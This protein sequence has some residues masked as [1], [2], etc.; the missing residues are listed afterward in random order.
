MIAKKEFL[1]LAVLLV[2]LSGCCQ[3]CRKKSTSEPVKKAKKT[4]AYN[5]AAMPQAG[6]ELALND[7]FVD[8]SDLDDFITQTN[9]D[10]TRLAADEGESTVE[11][12]E[13]LA[14]MDEYA[15]DEE[16]DLNWES[17]A[18]TPERNLRTV[19]FGFNKY[20]VAN[21]QNDVIEQNALQISNALCEADSRGEEL[22]VVVEA[23]A[24]HSAGA[25][26]YNMGLSQ[27]RASTIADRLKAAGVPA[28]RMQVVGRGQELPAVIDG[29]PVTGSREE[30]WSNRRAQ[31]YLVNA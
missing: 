29:K 26:D 15:L 27:K 4:V 11:Q 25:P 9:Y 22:K 1:T 7:I 30:Q 13:E 17:D 28:E 31:L 23:H 12:V 5:E 19:Y 3:K 8:D 14:W 6:K 20:G 16:E 2:G 21:D 24:C 10:A 18:S